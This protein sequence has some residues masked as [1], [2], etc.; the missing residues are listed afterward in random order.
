MSDMTDVV[1]P[2]TISDERVLGVDRPSR[3]GRWARVS[4]L[5][6]RFPIFQLLVFG[7]VFVWGAVQLDGFASSSSLRAMAVLAALLA[8]ASLGQTFVILIGGLDLAVPGYITVGA[9]AAAQ[10]GGA[11]GWPLWQVVLFVV[12]VCGGAGG[13]IGW[14]CHRLRVQSLVLSLGMASILI[15]GTVV[16]TDAS[17]TGIPPASLGSWTSVLSTTFGLPVPPVVALVGVAVLVSWIV[18]AGTSIGRNLYATGANPVAAEEILIPTGRIWTAVF[19]AGAASTGVV[20]ILIAG[21][22]SGATLNTGDPYFYSGLA[23]VLVGG[24]A[25]GSAQGDFFRTVLGALTLTGLTTILSGYGFGEGDTRILYGA[26][27][28]VVVLA[29]GRGRRL[30]DRL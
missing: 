1:T 28:I 20:G 14:L 12:V 2:P 11:R 18:L 29:Y 15:G 17:I 9:V 4:A 26:A 6:S 22:S 8:L 25:L 24:T 27:I 30:R 10:L 23:A 19:A 7:A 5:S 21:F 13:L 16:V 3:R